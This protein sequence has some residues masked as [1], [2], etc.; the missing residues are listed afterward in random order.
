MTEPWIQPP[1]DSDPS[2]A[3]AHLGSDQAE[4]DTDLPAGSI[5]PPAPP[6]PD[7]AGLAQALLRQAHEQTSALGR[8]RALLVASEL[9]DHLGQAAAAAEHAR[10]AAEIAPKLSLAAAQARRLRADDDESTQRRLEATVRLADPGPT[11][12]HAGLLLAERLRQLGEADRAARVL[13]HIARADGGSVAPSPDARLEVE[14]LIHRL[15]QGEPTLGLKVDD[16][17]AQAA[18]AVQ[19][20]LARP[21]GSPQAFPAVP[22]QGGAPYLSLLRAAREIRAGR[23]AE[24]TELL[25]NASP[26]DEDVL[27]LRAAYLATRRDGAH[28]SKKPLLLALEAARARGG[29]TRMTW[30]ALALVALSSGDKNLLSWVQNE[31]DP[32]SGTFETSERLA[33]LALAGELPT[34]PAEEWQAIA[35]RLPMLARALAPLG[36][37]PLD[38]PTSD[39]EY[40]RLGAALRAGEPRSIRQELGSV[41]ATLESTGKERALAHLWRLIAHRQEGNLAGQAEALS[42]IAEWEGESA[43]ALGALLCEALGQHDRAAQAYAD[44]LASTPRGDQAPSHHALIARALGELEGRTLAQPSPDPALPTADLVLTLLERGSE[45]EARAALS[46]S[47][48]PGTEL[49]GSLL[50]AMVGRGAGL[51]IPPP[52]EEDVPRLPLESVLW[53]RSALK[54]ADLDRDGTSS[55]LGI[56]ARAQPSDPALGVLAR[57]FDPELRTAADAHA[58]SRFLEAVDVARACLDRPATEARSGL[59]ALLGGEGQLPLSGLLLHLAE[60]GDDHE[61]V[62]RSYLDIATSADD[63][64]DRRYAYGQLAEVDRERGQPKSSLLWWRTISEQWPSDVGALLAQEEALER[65]GELEELRK[66]QAR[67]ADALAKPEADAYRTVLAAAALGR[68]DLRGAQRHLEPFLEGETPHLLALRVLEAAS[69]EPDDDAA[70]LKAQLGLLPLL[71]SDLDQLACLHEAAMAAARLGRPAAAARHIEQA[72]ELRPLDFLTELFAVHLESED[73]PIDRAEALERVAQAANVP[74]HAAQF[75][76]TAGLTWRRVDDR[77]RAAECLQRSLDLE[78]T[79]D[80]AFEALAKLYKEESARPKLATL[81]EK[82]LL[83]EHTKQKRQELELELGHLWIELG[84]PDKAKILLEGTLSRHPSDVVVLRLHAELAAELGDHKAAEQSLVSLAQS[85]PPGSER[86]AV[87]RSLGRLYEKHFGALEKAMDAYQAALE[88]DGSDLDLVRTLVSVYARLGLAERATQLQT[89]LIQKAP[90]PDDKRREALELARLYEEV[91]A[92]PARAGATLER[93]RRAWPLDQ[94]V[95]TATAQFYERQGD[96]ERAR[97][98]VEQTSAEARHKLEGGK[99]DAGLLATLSAVA[100]LSGKPQSRDA[101][102]AARAAYLGE[103]GAFAA[104]GP[105]AL[106]ASLD[107]L[108]AP[109]VLIPPLRSLLKKASAALD[110]AFPI[111]LAPLDAHPAHDGPI[112]ARL[113]QICQVLGQPTPDVFVSAALGSRAVPLTTKP[114]RLIVGAE[115]E[116]LPDDSIDYLLAR[117]VKLQQLGAGA[118]ARSR[119]EDAWPM[120]VALMSIFAPNYRPQGV[121]QRKILQARALVEQ[122]LARTGYDPDVPALVLETIA[123]L[124]RQ[125]EGLAEAP[126]LLVNRAAMLLAGGP[127]AALLAMSFGDKKPLPESGPSRYRWIDAHAE[128]KDLLLF[129]A[130]DECATALARLTGGVRGR[131]PP[132]IG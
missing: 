120:I 72:R 108:L 93:T 85:L 31:A 90:L 87:H 92:D 67:L 103:A 125:T 114:L 57:S 115:L 47:T 102:A 126:R 56:L 21:Q 48:A 42:G 15:A 107:D 49:A 110:A 123:A 30:R 70:L 77:T 41:L 18:Q 116:A 54:R 74:H 96:P 127:G 132:R 5:D 129:C 69:P 40:L 109:P 79:D 27:H 62:S 68:M 3:N 88:A 80:T 52:A 9:E 45:E 23:I 35:E 22:S 98:L 66:V 20:L 81:L 121:D 122:G 8:A 24:A 83:E 6:M 7:L 118:L 64:L 71:T 28:A 84:A 29:P 124:R 119:P 112:A 63:P 106:D 99:L 46:E 44:L 50:D 33:L 58:S 82:R 105:K 14:R 19:E 73:E 55:A 37:L 104:V 1:G 131:A 10:D 95:L 39:D 53:T 113:T 76:R 32:A 60:L 130:S 65:S 34:F 25:V 17:L 94:A 97:V 36:S 111:D 91:A 12:L 61:A 78:P 100:A 43:L 13:D 2:E 59:R 51:S 117:A 86:T 75:W 38:P 4:A 101:I 89:E 11:R 128:A 26:E 16:S